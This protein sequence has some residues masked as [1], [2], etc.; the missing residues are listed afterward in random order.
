MNR[1][2]K[3]AEMRMSVYAGHGSTVDVYTNSFHSSCQIEKNH[4]RIHELVLAI[5]D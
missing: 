2:V 4:R 5:V 3:E 1:V